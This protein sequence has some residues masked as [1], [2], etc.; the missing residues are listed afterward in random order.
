MALPVLERERLASQGKRI[1][2]TVFPIWPFDLSLWG[3]KCKTQSFNIYV[4]HCFFFLSFLYSL[5]FFLTARS[6]LRCVCVSVCVRAAAALVL[7]NPEAH[8]PQQIFPPV[9]VGESV[10]RDYGHDLCLYR[11]VFYTADLLYSTPVRGLICALPCKTP[12]SAEA[13][14]GEGWTALRKRRCSASPST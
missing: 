4:V 11:A 10:H 1:A 13:N 14:A 9:M 5:S 12:E 7:G 8:L 2:A 3:R 6:G